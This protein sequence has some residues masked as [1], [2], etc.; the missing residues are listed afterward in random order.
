MDTDGKLSGA[1]RWDAPC[2]D[3]FASTQY[4]DA[5]KRLRKL[6]SIQEE[7][8]QSV[9]VW[10]AEQTR[11]RLPGHNGISIYFNNLLPSCPSNGPRNS[12]MCW[13]WRNRACLKPHNFCRVLTIINIKACHNHYC[14]CIQG[15]TSKWHPPPH[16]VPQGKMREGATKR[17]ALVYRALEFQWRAYDA[18]DESLS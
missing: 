16:I 3:R 2:N 8:I 9:Y 15:L 13:G 10:G 1:L 5:A 14:L 11:A 4:P 18:E 7:E 6:L 17:N 12:G